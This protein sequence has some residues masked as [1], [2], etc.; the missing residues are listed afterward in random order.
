ML[1]SSHSVSVSF[2]IANSIFSAPWSVPAVPAIWRRDC[3]PLLR[4]A[5]EPATGGAQRVR[6]HRQQPHLSRDV[7]HPVPQQDGPAEGE[8][9]ASR[10]GPRRLLP[11][12]PGRWAFIF[13][14][15]T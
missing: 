11:R 4:Q 10:H 3:E 8:G 13:S 15:Y 2:S 5:D 6:H 9:A 14:N 1:A 7:R 12:V